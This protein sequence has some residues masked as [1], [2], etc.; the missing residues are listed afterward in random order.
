[1]G[2][3]V[4]INAPIAHA[5]Q[6]PAPEEIQL[7]WDAA[8]RNILVSWANGSPD[9]HPEVATSVYF[10][11]SGS[12]GGDISTAQT[13]VFVDHA[14]VPVR[15]FPL[16]YQTVRVGV[17]FL[18]QDFQQFSPFAYS[19]TF[20]TLTSKIA[21]TSIQPTTD[22]R[23]RL[24]WEPSALPGDQTPADVLDQPVG[25][26]RQYVVMTS[27]PTP[28]GST[29]AYEGSG[30][31]AAQTAT[32]TF[33]WRNASTRWQQGGHVW[34]IQVNDWPGRCECAGLASRLEPATMPWVDGTAISI[35][36][37]RSATYGLTYP[38]QGTVTA[39]KQDDRGECCL[40]PPSAGRTVVLHGRN[41]T[42]SPWYAIGSRVTDANGHFRFDVAAAGTRQLRTLVLATSDPTAPGLGV[43][44][45][46]VT[47]A[48]TVRVLSARF[49]DPSVRRGQRVTALLSVY[50]YSNG[51]ATLQRWDGHRWIGVKWVS[52]QNGLG[53]YA[54]TA[55][56]LGT[57]AFRFVVPPLVAPNR[58][59]VA[60][61][62]THTFAL[63]VSP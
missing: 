18:S 54:F 5:I 12:W 39:M 37:P 6:P 57:T 11:D 22:A 62:T 52:L 58:L 8:K 35:V 33:P 19:S 20:D 60:G 48:S 63:R 32:V 51:V 31:T 49:V 27:G 36:Y 13:E 3:L 40:Q 21:I 9:Y 43:V 17:R 2:V 10:E 45:E 14:V 55:S 7:A 15:Q 44:T 53:W 23:V 47:V 30:P 61:T 59:P 4:F 41:T 42:T 24:A 28:P 38:L 25:D 34:V 50:P 1:M 16:G 29:G 26:T 56:T 46:P